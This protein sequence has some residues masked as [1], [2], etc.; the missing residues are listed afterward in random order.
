MYCV[1]VGDIVNSRELEPS[2]REKVTR[3]AQSAFDRINTD[4]IDVLMTT[5]GMV[6]G[7]AFEGVMLSQHY[8]PRIV[9]DIIKAIYRVEK[10]K[11]RIAVVL[12]HL[13]VTDYDRNVVDGPAFHKAFDNLAKMKAS[14]NDHWLQV[15]FDIGPLAQGLVDSQLGLLSALTR[16]WTARQQEIV[17]AMEAHGC[18][19]KITARQLGITSAAAMKKH[20]RAANFEAYR[21]AWDGLTDF[22]I[23]IDEYTANDTPIA[24]KSYLTYF[25]L[26]ERRFFTHDYTEAER[27]YKKSLELAQNDLSEDDPLLIPVHNKLAEVYFHTRQLVYGMKEIEK[28]LQLQEG[29]PKA[30][31]Q[32]AETLLIKAA[33][34]SHIN[35]EQAKQ[36]YEDV[37]S[38]ARDIL[39]EAHPLFGIIYSQLASFYVNASKEYKKALEYYYLALD[40]L[41]NNKRTSPVNYAIGISNIALCYFRINDFEKAV[42]H[43]E[44]TLAIYEENLPPNHKYMGGARAMVE[45]ARR[46]LEGGGDG[47]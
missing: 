29:M 1:I 6:R 20:L 32:Y 22:L 40:V 23:K 5:F 35:F 27:L 41:E 43:W 8:A 16:G 3:A 47:A 44:K 39:N 21:Q 34:D 28:S 19:E 46:A 36:G 26:A 45:S 7:D 42:V 14:K 17:W 11:V 18:D 13:S 33:L 24:E 10:T 4:Y 31:L 37:L 30:R 38:I 9:Q 12:G 15:S 2:V 25:N